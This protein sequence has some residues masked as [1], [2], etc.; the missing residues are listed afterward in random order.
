[1]RQA[2][3]VLALTTACAGPVPPAP[4]VT[5]EAL[6]N[7]V[8]ICDDSGHGR[9]RL[10]WFREQIRGVQIRIDSPR[11][12]L[13]AS[14]PPHGDVWTGKWV[15]DGMRFVLIDEET[16]VE[17]AETVVKVIRDCSDESSKF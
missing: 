11:G 6:P 9:V 8:R 12:D 10:A 1:M 7:P 5:F 14:E 15:T 2:A 16:G 4:A 3:V 13:V 17:L